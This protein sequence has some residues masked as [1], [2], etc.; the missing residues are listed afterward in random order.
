MIAQQPRS[1]SAEIAPGGAR[2]EFDVRVWREGEGSPLWYLH[3][4]ET[5]PG[6]A[7]VLRALAADR[8]LV[9]PEHPGYGESTGFEQPTFLATLAAAHA[10]LGEFSDAAQ[11]QREARSSF[12][13]TS[14]LLSLL[15]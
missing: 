9:A 15:A 5:H 1:T 6:A 4:F 7:S 3:G 14:L 12:L 2:G 11:R 8:Q 10:E 13:E